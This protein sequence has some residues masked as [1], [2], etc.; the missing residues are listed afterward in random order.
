MNTPIITH[1]HLGDCSE[2]LMAFGQDKSTQEYILSGVFHKNGGSL[3]YSKIFQNSLDMKL[4]T[5]PSHR[6][7]A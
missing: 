6:V 2:S 4:P 5:P 1:Y 3:D 7:C